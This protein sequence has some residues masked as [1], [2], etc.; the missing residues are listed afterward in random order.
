MSHR[1]QVHAETVA[2]CKNKRSG[3]CRFNADTCWWRH[4]EKE[5]LQQ[6]QSIKCFICNK[7]FETKADMMIHRKRIHKSMVRKCT[8][9]IKYQCRFQE[10]FCWFVH[11]NE[12][13][14]IENS[15]ENDQ[16]SKETEHNETNS[17]FQKV[18]EDLKPPERKKK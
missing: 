15:I 10:K 4:E 6:V 18:K 11:E 12:E 3:T 14:E 16:N 7:I 17:V 13:M 1:K 9:Y 2:F 8:D 5:T